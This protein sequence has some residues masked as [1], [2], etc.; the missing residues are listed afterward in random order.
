L[1][2]EPYIFI[3]S[4]LTILNGCGETGTDSKGSSATQTEIAPTFAPTPKPTS[5]ESFGVDSDNRVKIIGRVT[6]DRVPSNSNGIGLN[7]DN[8][9]IR[10]VKLARV[11]LVN[12]Y[13]GSQ[14][15]IASTETDSDGNYGFYSVER[16]QN[17]RVCIYSEMK[18]SGEY[19]F[20]VVNN[21][22]GDALYVLSS[23][24]FNTDSGKRVDLHADSGWGGGGYSGVRQAAP[25]AILDSIYQAMKKV[26]DADSSAV[27]PKLKANW[28]IYNVPAGTG[29]EYELR[30]GLIGTTHFDG[31]G[32]LYILG[33]ADS[34]TDE[35]DDHVIIHEWG[36]YFEQSFSRADSIGGPHGSGD[37]LDI[38]V[39][40]GEGWGN[41]FSAIA[42]DNPIYFD[43]QGFRQSSGFSMD[44]ESG[45]SDIKGYFSEDSVQHI[46]YDIYDS[47]D[48]GADRLS[49]GFKPIYNVLTNFQKKT[50]AFTSIFTFIKGVEEFDSSNMD[51]V[52]DI[53]MSEDIPHIS[54]IYGSN[55]D[56]TLYG[57]ME[58]LDNGYLCTSDRYGIY[59]KLYNHRYLKF[60]IYN[61]RYYQISVVQSNG[62]GSDP[63]FGLYYTSPFKHL[64]N[65]EAVKYNIEIDEH[66][67]KKGSY[68]LDVSDYNGLKNPCFKVTIK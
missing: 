5:S 49:L 8:I 9:E 27:F 30:S 4:I 16:G 20:K 60:N 52:D 25:F 15:I 1:K 3:F 45:K 37:R 12:G 32:N 41:A 57:Y 68:L 22:D 50:E 54:D 13:C 43:T 62:S 18:R 51:I 46:I 64:G 33:D 55:I 11:E 59:N 44:I 19:D 17:L 53:L 7:Y 26:R 35:Y 66:F 2:I 67:L 38:R 56:P 42:T 34:D 14:N 24:N 39:A 28:S 23:S 58:D 65:S 29:S 61:E 40:F 10:G 63:D 36:H 21:T 48:D 6:Y 31:D 47:N